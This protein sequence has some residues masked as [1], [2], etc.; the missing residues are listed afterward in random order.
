MDIDLGRWI[1]E[2]LIRQHSLDDRLLNTLI[3]VLPS[4]NNDTSIQKS[5]LLRKLE[6][7]IEKGTISER[8]LEFFEQIEELDHRE[9]NT[10]VSEAMKSAYC[11]VAVHCTVKIIKESEDD[12]QLKYFSAVRTIWRSRIREMEKF[13]VANRVGLISDNLLVWMDD[14]EAGVWVSNYFDKILVKYKE[15]DALKAVCGYV[16]EAKEKMGPTFLEL[17]AETLGDDISREVLD[18]GK[19]EEHHDQIKEMAANDAPNDDQCVDANLNSEDNGVHDRVDVD[20]PNPSFDPNGED[21]HANVDGVDDVILRDQKER[22]KISLMER[23]NTAHRLE[24]SDSIDNSN[25]ESPKKRSISPLNYKN[26]KLPQKRK[27]MRWTIT[28]EDT[29]RTGV[30]KYG[31]GNWKLILN[32]YREI[33]VDRTEVDLKDK[34]RNLTR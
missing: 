33:F 11:A 3:R 6:S 9:G 27:K 14:L 25:K 1:L 21:L 5:L 15:L 26:K 23:N 29:L 12:D 24:W 30:L 32:M 7:D 17:V 13:D 34:W 16:T 18:L 19:D 4:S 31:K 20:D 28:E 2:F 22:P 8:T 10:E